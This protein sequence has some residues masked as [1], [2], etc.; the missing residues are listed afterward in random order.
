MRVRT[1]KVPFAKVVPAEATELEFGP[2]DYIVV[3]PVFGLSASRLQHYLDL[4]AKATADLDPERDE[5][6]QLAEREAMS[7]QL[8][9]DLL[10]EGVREWHLSDED[11]KAIARPTTAE[12]IR[13]LP[14][15]LAGN[16]YNFLSTY[17]GDAENPTIPR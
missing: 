14:G 2:D 11:G 13:A 16:L 12:E 8:V 15:A 5:K 7:D 10:E 4:I 17:R 3:R 6:A 9:L 1:F